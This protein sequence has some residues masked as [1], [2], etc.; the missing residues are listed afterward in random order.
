MNTQSDRKICRTADERVAAVVFQSSQQRPW[1]CTS[2]QFGAGF[3]PDEQRPN[4]QNRSAATWIGF[5]Q[6]ARRTLT[7]NSKTGKTICFTTEQDC[8]AAACKI[9]EHL[10]TTFSKTRSP[11]SPLG[12]SFVPDE[13]VPNV[14]NHS[15]ATKVSF[16]QF[17][18]GMPTMNSKPDQKSSAPL[19]SVSGAG[20]P[21]QRASLKHSSWRLSGGDRHTSITRPCHTEAKT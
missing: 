18:K 20:L 19:M 11:K 17:A 12:I 8:A 10:S 16:G 9:S 3:I 14:Q 6:F 2:Q 7:M 15:H 21:L 4:I 5:G 13:H 1:G